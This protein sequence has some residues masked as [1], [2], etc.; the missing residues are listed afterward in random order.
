LKLS[1]RRDQILVIVLTVVLGISVACFLAGVMRVTRQP[2][3]L[4]L[5]EGFLW[6]QSEMVAEGTPLY[7]P[8]S[9]TQL[10]IIPHTPLY[11]VV[12]GWL[13]KIFGSSL[14]V[15]RLVSLCS[16]LFLVVL[17]FL[18]TKKVTKNPT[19][20]LVA[21]A[22][23]VS[24]FVF[25]FLAPMYRM[26]TMGVMLCFLGIY[27][28]LRFEGRGKLIYWSIPIFVLA[29]YTK[30]NYI[31]A[32]IS[33]CIYLLASTHWNFRSMLKY[34]LVYGLVLAGSLV[35]GGLLTDWQLWYHNI[36]YIG[37]GSILGWT[38]FWGH[39]RQYFF[40]HGPLIVL[41]VGYIGYRFRRGF[42]VSLISIYFWVALVGFLLVIGKVGGGF[43]YGF[44]IAVLGCI[45]TGVLLQ[46][47]LKV[48][49][50]KFPI[51][52]LKGLGRTLLGGGVV[53]LIILQVIGIPLGGGF[54]QYQLSSDC[55]VLTE[56]VV[57]Y[58]QSVGEPIFTDCHALALLAG[59]Q[60]EWSR[61]EAAILYR[62]G[63]QNKSGSLRWD[64]SDLVSKFETGYYKSV[65]L[66]YDL[67]K[68]WR[69]DTT[70][71][72]FIWVMQE[73]L[74]PEVSST[75]IRNYRPVFET[76]NMGSNFQMYKTYAYE[77]VG[78]N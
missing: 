13:S 47:S 32:P 58:F 43:H 18:I 8:V 2:Y 52:T 39:L 28:F 72:W 50:V 51:W 24:T 35:V 22:L 48:F 30:Q 68:V 41:I 29:F 12:C 38:A 49:A 66:H 3:E 55:K 20:S 9:D 27:L 63:F 36:V 40:Y 75:I 15:G 34:G 6:M 19:V 4:I 76:E 71:S 60:V 62:G 73:K 64:Q 42:S 10:L 77:Y 16:G 37:T 31:W 26:D 78:E 67:F 23:V 44:E 1:L 69:G 14:E 33:V 61:W 59:H 56:E 53:T 65:I 70:K 7:S 46:R 21:A 5:G 25:R 11:V 17:T 54:V 45:M 57:R 74:S